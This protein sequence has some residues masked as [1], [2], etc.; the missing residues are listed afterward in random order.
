MGHAAHFLRRLDRLADPQ[1]E[2]AL[3]LYNDPA[4]LG[5]TLQRAKLPEGA[6][7]VALA[8]VDP[9]EGPYVIV[10]REG[11]F[12]TCLAR[13]MR[14][15]LP[16][17]TRAQLDAAARDV[18]RAREMIAQ[19]EY[20]AENE[21]LLRQK[22][23]QLYEAGPYLSREQL[24][25]IARW[26]P[27]LGDSLL[28]A[29]VDVSS[30][31]LLAKRRLV[32]VTRPKRKHERALRRYWSD[33]WACSHLYVLAA[34]SQSSR[35]MLARVL[36]D[37]SFTW[38]WPGVSSGVGAV[39][40]R[41]LWSTA[42]V[43]KAQLPGLKARLRDPVT[44]FGLADGFLA[45]AA[46]GLHS[47]KARGEAFKLLR[48]RRAYVEMDREYLQAMD[49]ILRELTKLLADA[50]EELEEAHAQASQEVMVHVAEHL[51]EEFRYE[52]REDA[53]R[54]LARSL[55]AQDTSAVLQPERLVDVACALPWL[56]SCEPTDLYLPQVLVDAIRR[57]YDAR[58]VIATLELERQEHGA[59]RPVTAK[60]RPGR[61][62]PCECGSGAKFKRCCG[63]PGAA[64]PN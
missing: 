27:L 16:V 45:T 48:A 52:R 25:D 51:P 30:D 49:G 3:R 59:P 34:L 44:F 7:R 58:A 10:T 20:C 12:V 60:A 64:T 17:V 33:L 41:A 53:P 50:P 24:E 8:L 1:V 35:E 6:E 21:G 18:E 9:V 37:G 29:C 54:D 14:V 36:A 13:G 39:V 5:A 26:E 61:N 42:R 40:Y 63:R 38:S 31:V 57:P 2:L 62:D 47:A 43:G 23:N 32:G 11:R 22:F 46:V 28:R 56:A 19:L 4:L 15:D 55:S